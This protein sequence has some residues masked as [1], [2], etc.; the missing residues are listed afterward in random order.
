MRERDPIPLPPSPV[1]RGRG[2]TNVPK[3]F[4]FGIQQVGDLHGF[5][6]GWPPDLPL[7][8]AGIR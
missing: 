8:V 1:R 5:F 7:M 2:N 6:G 3:G 4:A